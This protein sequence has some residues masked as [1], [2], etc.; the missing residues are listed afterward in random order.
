[1]PLRLGSLL[2]EVGFADAFV[3]EQCGGIA[4][5][6]DT[7]RFHHVGAMC[8]LQC[9]ARVLLDQQHGDAR[10]VDFADGIED[11]PDQERRQPQ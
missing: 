3:G 6:G 2:S 8:N 4:G 5:E 7:P 11:E 1:L 9:G 10:R